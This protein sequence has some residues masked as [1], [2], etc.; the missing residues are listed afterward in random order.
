MLESE[1]GS[2]ILIESISFDP[3]N[4]TSTVFF[5]EFTIHLGLCGSDELGI[6][7]EANYT[8][9]SKTVV[10]NR[11]DWTLAA[12]PDWFSIELDTPFWY[13]GSGNLIIDF[14]WPDGVDE[15]YNY[16]WDTGSNRSLYADYGMPTGTNMTDIP[17]MLLNGTLSLNQSTFGRIKTLFSF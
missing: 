1:I 12:A 4:P 16:N 5:D 11:T 7:F 9:G 10:F 13:S 17:H 15:I 14:E 3:V 6:D 8:T 2:A